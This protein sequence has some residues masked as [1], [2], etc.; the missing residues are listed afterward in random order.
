M[1]IPKG[2]S[3]KDLLLDFS[4]NM[5]KKMLAENGA[6]ADL[7]DTEFSMVVDVSGTQYGYLVKNGTDFNVKEG[8]L[9]NPMVT[10]SISEA[11][12]KKMIETNSLDMLLGIQSDLNKRKYQA[13][14]NLKGK[15]VA[16][17]SN[18]DGSMVTISTVFNGAET[19]AATFKMKTSDSIA[20][21]KK[22][23]IFITMLEN[24]YQSWEI[25]I[26]KA[27]FEINLKTITPID[28][29]RLRIRSTVDFLVSDPDIC[30]IVMTM[31]FGLPPDLE[32]ATRRI[33]EKIIIIA[34]N[35]FKL[36]IHNNHVR[37]NLNVR[38][39]GE[40]MTGAIFSSVYFDLLRADKNPRMVNVETLTNEIVELFAPGIFR[41]EA[42]HS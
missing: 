34:T 32:E 18:A 40:M 10:I 26:Q 4:P 5:A 14:K 22:E 7:A 11:D 38:H 15:M 29:L 31:G 1:D 28:Y 27:V 41:P 39:V 13:L 36:G 25:A 3:I 21:V 35:D 16:K 20:L 42:I 33:E 2:L 6:A 8:N 12:L 9:N 24:A 37:E 19:P 23:D 30:N 17:L